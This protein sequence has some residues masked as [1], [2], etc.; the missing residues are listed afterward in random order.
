MCGDSVLNIPLFPANVVH[1]CLP[2]QVRRWKISVLFWLRFE[3]IPEHPESL[4]SCVM[5]RN[6]E[7]IFKVKCESVFG[8]HLLSWDSCTRNWRMYFVIFTLKM[9]LGT[10][11]NRH[12]PR[13]NQNAFWNN[14]NEIT[15]GNKTAR[16]QMLAT[17]LWFLKEGTQKDSLATVCSLKMAMLCWFFEGCHSQP[18]TEAAATLELCKSNGTSITIVQDSRDCQ[19]IDH[20]RHWWAGNAR[21]CTAGDSV[22]THSPPEIQNTVLETQLHGAPLGSSDGSVTPGLK[23]FLGLYLRC[24]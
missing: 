14:T 13:Q 11:K 3:N 5:V 17:L 20:R 16:L 19:W 2:L 23:N 18:C 21:S 1:R 22:P 8:A 7:T 9:R 12:Q 24:E 6:K 10:M 4:F 15:A